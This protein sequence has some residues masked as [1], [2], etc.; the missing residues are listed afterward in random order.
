LLIAALSIDYWFSL[1]EARPCYHS[2]MAYRL[3]PGEK[4]TTMNKRFTDEQII[5]SVKEAEAS[6][7]E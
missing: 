5:G 2:S 3:S 7:P 6:M 4:K 1:R